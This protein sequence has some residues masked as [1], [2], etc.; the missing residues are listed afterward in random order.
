MS[1]KGIDMRFLHNRKREKGGKRKYNIED[2]R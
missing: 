2:E 1:Q